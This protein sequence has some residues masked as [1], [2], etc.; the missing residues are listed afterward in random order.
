MPKKNST[1]AD[2]QFHKKTDLNILD[3]FANG[4]NDNTNIKDSNKN[5]NVLLS[6]LKNKPQKANINDRSNDNGMCYDPTQ[7]NEIFYVDEREHHQQQQKSVPSLSNVSN[8]LKSSYGVGSMK[9]SSQQQQQQ[10]SKND[11]LEKLGGGGG[12]GMDMDFS[13][14]AQQDAYG[15]V[16]SHQQQPSGP[17]GSSNL[18]QKIAMLCNNNPGKSVQPTSTLGVLNNQLKG[19]SNINNLYCDVDDVESVNPEEILDST[20]M[21][22]GYHRNSVNQIQNFMKGNPANQAYQ[23]Y[24]NQQAPVTILSQQQQ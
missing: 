11:L 21:H 4:F 16:G 13:V 17:P 9:H 5:N 3:N 6:L 23:N 10:S 8:Q 19:Q 18:S 1:Q 24:H 7:T 14:G 15:Y 12:S 20:M 22:Q 2:N